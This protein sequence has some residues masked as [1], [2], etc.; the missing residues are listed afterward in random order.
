MLQLGN[1][2]C[3][4]LGTQSRTQNS[5]FSRF[6]SQ[7]S[8]RA[9]QETAWRAACTPN[10]RQLL[11]SLSR[12]HT[13]S[14]LFDSGTV[15]WVLRIVISSHYFQLFYRNQSSKSSRGME[16]HTIARHLEQ[17]SA[18]LLCEMGLLPPAHTS[19]QGSGL[20]MG[21]F[22]YFLWFTQC[23]LGNIGRESETGSRTDT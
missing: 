22:G 5:Q 8:R 17:P 16:F 4:L 21:S 3:R 11:G 18:H 6:A 12:G 13:P 23:M 20:P 9:F 2:R 15:G 10:R 7:P 19:F 14:V 1:K